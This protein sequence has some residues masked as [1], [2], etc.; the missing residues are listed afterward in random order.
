MNFPTIVKYSLGLMIAIQAIVIAPSAEAI[1]KPRKN[2]DGVTVL[3][4]DKRPTR[5]RRTGKKVKIK[6]RIY[7]EMICPQRR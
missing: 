6:G 5:C 1:C 4:C 3:D 7:W 2:Q